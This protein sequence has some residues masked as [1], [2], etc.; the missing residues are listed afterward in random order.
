MWLWNVLQK[1]LLC[2]NP[3]WLHPV[4]LKWLMVPL[5]PV[6]VT[7]AQIITCGWCV[8]FGPGSVCEKLQIQWN[9][10][11]PPGSLLALH[12]YTGETEENLSLVSCIMACLC[13]FSTPM[14]FWVTSAP[15]SSENFVNA[16]FFHSTDSVTEFPNASFC[17]LVISTVFLCRLKC[18]D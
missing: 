3:H 16:V 9:H 5:P 7:V 15:Y 13:D 6:I 12:T 18:V 2:L 1:P 17:C 8:L 14:L 4:F 10:R 11:T